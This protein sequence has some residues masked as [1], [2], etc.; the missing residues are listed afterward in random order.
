MPIRLD[1]LARA[2]ALGVALIAAFAGCGGDG[3]G[4]D[5]R[6]PVSLTKISGDNQAAQLGNPLPQPLRV[7]VTNFEEQGLDG[8]AVEFSVVT[9]S[10]TVNP[11]IDTTAGGGFAETGVT[12]GTNGGDVQIRAA[13]RGSSVPA[14]VFAATA[15]G[16][17]SIA[18]FSGDGQTGVAG[19]PFPQPL[20]AIVRDPRGSAFPGVAVEWAVATAPGPGVV[21]DSIRTTTDALGIASTTGRFGDVAGTYSFMASIAGVA[22]AAATFS[23]SAVLAPIIGAIDPSPII[24][25]GTATITGQNFAAAA[26]QNTVTVDGIAAT[27]LSGSTTQLSIAVPRAACLPARDSARI[28]VTVS[29]VTGPTFHHPAIP[30]D[31]PLDLAVGA[32]EIR[33]DSAGLECVQMPARTPGSTHL[34]IAAITAT[35][36]FTTPERLTRTAGRATPFGIGGFARAT[37]I[38][39]ASQASRALEQEL[40][41]LGGARAFE[42]RIRRFER[43]H[44]SPRAGPA[45]P[46]AGGAA[47]VGVPGAAPRAAVPMVG[48]TLTLNVP[49]GPNFC[50]DVRSVKTRVKAVGNFGIAVEDT[51]RPADG[52]TDADYAQIVA[53]FDAKIYA[54]DTLYFGSPVTGSAAIDSVPHSFLVFTAEV[55]R[56]TPQGANFVI[57]GF[58]FAGDLLPTQCPGLNRRKIFYLLVP[59]PNGTINGN[60]RSTAFVRQQSRGTVA[61]ELQHLISAAQKIQRNAPTFETVWLGE[62]LSH[63]A[64]EVVGHAVTGLTPGSDLTFAQANAN[65]NDFTAFYRQNF[66]RARLY[67]LTD[68]IARNSPIANNDELAT[69][70]ATWLLLR[71]ILDHEGPAQGGEQS[72]TRKMV[73]TTASG[74]PNLESAVGKPFAGLVSEWL[75]AL[76]TDNLGVPGLPA[77]LTIPSW[78]L[79]DVYRNL[80][81]NDPGGYPLQPTTLPFTSGTTNFDVKAGSGRFF[82]VPSAGP[83]PALSLRF[84]DQGGSPLNRALLQPR[85]LVVRTQ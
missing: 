53:E 18:V 49:V 72:I 4:P 51:A 39:A 12:L 32:N 15:L 57:L 76:H 70:G 79:R 40:R 41:A 50:T 44:L 16:P 82:L 80:A 13:I 43:E 3:T 83:S 59:D 21:L 31:P 36:D 74:I 75:P 37:A 14:V 56:L 71:W 64:E 10:G 58:F 45:A 42:E 29:G 27:V 85:T 78:D 52:F 73:I 26:A 67:L 68:S 28:Q 38:L 5:P 23:L 62:G 2:A 65:A 8:I 84:T 33:A 9:G 46:Q 17:T 19:A 48:D 7:Q 61:H 6:R 22:G 63:I 47:A 54:T 66:L 20:R 1:R 55:N 35:Q 11:A 81:P 30:A 60:V 25:G 77:R 69:R 24:E 34:V